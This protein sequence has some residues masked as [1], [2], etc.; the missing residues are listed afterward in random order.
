MLL[1]L[2]KHRARYKVLAK[3]YQLNNTIIVILFLYF[4]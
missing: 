2:P 1:A 3:S 4:L